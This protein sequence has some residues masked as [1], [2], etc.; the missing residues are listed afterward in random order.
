MSEYY[1]CLRGAL[2]SLLIGVFRFFFGGSF[3]S[4]SSGCS[5]WG[6]SLI[7]GRVDS[8]GGGRI[9]WVWRFARSFSSAFER[10]DSKVSSL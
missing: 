3:C 8:P 6:S 7:S 1:G 5:S 9:N 4:C 10:G 2:G